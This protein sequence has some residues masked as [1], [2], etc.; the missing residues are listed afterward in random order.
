MKCS[1]FCICNKSPN[2]IRKTFYVNNEYTRSGKMQDCNVSKYTNEFYLD[3][4]PF[5]RGF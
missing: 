1:S 3:G 2:C 5:D 4:F